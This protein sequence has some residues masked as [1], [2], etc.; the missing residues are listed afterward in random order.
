MKLKTSVWSNIFFLLPL[1]LAFYYQIYFHTTLLFVAM[2]ISTLFHIYKSYLLGKLDVILA[3]LVIGN[4]FRLVYLSGFNEPYFI[5]AVLLVVASFYYF[6][7]LKK[8]DWEWH[9]LCSLITVFC[10]L[11]Y[12]L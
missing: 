8:D 9:L 6:F 11:G 1:I 3:L 12:S 4:N 10:I 5:V 2:I 7:K